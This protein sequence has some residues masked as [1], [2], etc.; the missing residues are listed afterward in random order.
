[1]EKKSASYMHAELAASFIITVSFLTLCRVHVQPWFFLL[2]AECSSGLLQPDA[3]SLSQ[4]SSAAQLSQAKPS[5]AKP[6]KAKHSSASVRQA[7][8]S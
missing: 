1:M 4:R 7:K 8:P 5:Y 6:G 2:L 3:L